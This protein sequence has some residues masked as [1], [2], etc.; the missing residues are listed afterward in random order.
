[1]HDSSAED[2]ELAELRIFSARIGSDPLLIQGAGGNTSLKIGEKLWI[3]ASGTQLAEALDRQIMVP[4]A[5]APLLDAVS[6]LDDAA[7]HAERFIV[8]GSGPDSLRPSIETT[9]H[10]VMPQRVVVHVHCVNTIALVVRSDG[11]AELARRLQGLDWALIPYV[12]PGLPLALAV[13]E[14][15]PSRPQ[16][17]VM[18]NHGLVVAAETIAAAEALLHDVTHR[19]AVP[20][21]PT[22]PADIDALHAL[23]AG[24][25]D[26]AFRL[27]GDEAAHAVA[28]DPESL[29]IA[30]R[31]SLYPDH[32]IFLGD[33]PAIA[34]PSE[35]VSTV[36][37]RVGHAP[38]SIIFPG[39]GVLMRHD[40]TRQ[41]DG[42]ARCLADVAAR[43]PGKASVRVLTHDERSQ[44][45][46]WDAEK[47]RQALARKTAPA[48]V[49]N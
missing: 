18:A 33:G 10:A 26:I 22:G 32:V 43:I 49:M 11:E 40:A 14:H 4:I 31:G 35:D 8:G 41:A 7:E 36:I 25:G 3:K 28:L 45:T 29:D 46:N 16:V 6:Q 38:V 2:A 1:M 44:L 24:A 42:M 39:L 34:R 23:A 17:L 37:Q 21:R 30:S 19:L 15:V 12:R 9:L 47:Y 27:P 48:E 20:A 5:M 13:A